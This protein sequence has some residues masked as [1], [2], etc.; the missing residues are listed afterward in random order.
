MKEVLAAK[1]RARKV[2]SEKL[3]LGWKSA[4]YNDDEGS[5]GTSY[6]RA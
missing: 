3:L 5:A 2:D 1:L 6:G 4:V